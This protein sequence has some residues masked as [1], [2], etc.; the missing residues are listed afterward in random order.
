MAKAD[1]APKGTK[2]MAGSMATL[3]PM[4][5]ANGQMIDDRMAPCGDNQL[6]SKDSDGDEY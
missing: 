4:I 2:A 1:K 5:K 3:Q 6:S